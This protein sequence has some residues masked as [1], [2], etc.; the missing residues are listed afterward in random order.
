[1]TRYRQLF[2]K[3]RQ[4]AEAHRKKDEHESLDIFLMAV[5]SLFELHDMI[6][7]DGHT[8]GLAHVWVS[9]SKPEE[10][11]A[12][13][14]ETASASGT[15]RGGGGKRRH[16]CAMRL[17]LMAFYA[18][19]LLNITKWQSEYESGAHEW[20]AGNADSRCS[21]LPQSPLRPPRTSPQKRPASK[22]HLRAERLI[23][24]ASCPDIHTLPER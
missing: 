15:N 8:D 14:P 16:D 3:F 1:M 23:L 2:E 11:T 20:I 22:R 17:D 6:L 13:A 5:D 7:S 18:N 24:S 12:V 10:Q 9:T 21:P 4:E 19:D